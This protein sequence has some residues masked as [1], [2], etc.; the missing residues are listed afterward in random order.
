MQT[1][2]SVRLKYWPFFQA[3]RHFIAEKV[4]ASFFARNRQ[5]RQK[6][7]TTYASG[8]KNRSRCFSP[9]GRRYYEKSK[10]SLSD[11]TTRINAIFWTTLFCRV[12]QSSCKR[13]YRICHRYCHRSVF[14]VHRTF[15]ISEGQ[16]RYAGLRLLLY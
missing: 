15:T 6:L 7:G 5:Y 16:A 2:Y 4:V 13:L 1:V 11:S 9:K 8:D 3:N 14:V 10:R 12:S